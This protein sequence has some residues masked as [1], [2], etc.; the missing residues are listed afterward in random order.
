MSAAKKTKNPTHMARPSDL[1]TTAKKKAFA[2]EVA[3]SIV[4]EVNAERKRMG[5]PPLKD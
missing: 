1:D 2:N 5:K 4:A 3:E